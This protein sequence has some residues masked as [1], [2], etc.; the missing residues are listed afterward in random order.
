MSPQ[1]ETLAI[2]ESLIAYESISSRSNLDIVAYIQS[3]LSHR[4]VRSQRIPDA[5]GEKA[6]ILATIGPADKP[7]VVLSAHTDVVP[8]EGQNWSSPPFTAT[9]KNGRVTGRGATDMKGFVACVL[10]HVEHFQATATVAPVHIGFSYD[11]EVGC[12][13]APDLVAAVASMPALP[14]L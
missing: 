4:N 11:E 6:S 14:A 8:V 1:S 2:L 7:G 10:S 9:L 12:K 13:G 5:T 3:Y